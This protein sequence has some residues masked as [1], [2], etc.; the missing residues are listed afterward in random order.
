L[1]GQR[2]E[3]RADGLAMSPMT[4]D[5]KPTVALVDDEPALHDLVRE[6][7]KTTD[8]HF[9]G[10]LSAADFQHSLNEIRTGCVLVDVRLPD[11]SGLDLLQ[12]LVAERSALP[13]IILTGYGNVDTA[14]RALKSGA[15]DFIEKPFR[16]DQLRTCIQAAVDISCSVGADDVSGVDL[17]A[18]LGRLTPR[19]REILQLIVRGKSN[20]EIASSLQITRKTLDVHRSRIRD[21]MNV[22]TETCLV[23]LLLL[24]VHCQ[25][26]ASR[27]G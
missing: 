12:H 11:M 14:V 10:F 4:M 24:G 7:V 20:K 22:Q 3:S 23:R 18:R 21:K 13:V 2:R 17:P 26:P 8:L 25:A 16:P 27:S 6:V 15:F 5:P 1:K 19:E 9:R